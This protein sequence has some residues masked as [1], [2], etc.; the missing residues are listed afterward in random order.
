M[1][2]KN[3]KVGCYFCLCSYFLFRMNEGDTPAQVR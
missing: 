1:L 3:P 2:I